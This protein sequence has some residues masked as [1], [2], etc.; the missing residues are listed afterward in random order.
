MSSTSLRPIYLVG[1]P[2]AGNAVVFELLAQASNICTLGRAARPRLAALL[3]QTPAADL[4]AGRVTSAPA[5]QL[6]RLVAEHFVDVNGNPAV[7][8]AHILHGRWARGLRVS[9]LHA[10]F[11]Q[12]R[13]IYVQRDVAEQIATIMAHRTGGS[14]AAAEAEWTGHTGQLIEDL[15]ALPRHLWCTVN[16]NDLLHDVSHEAASLGRFIDVSWSDLSTSGPILRRHQARAITRIGA[17]LH[18]RPA[19]LTMAT[20]AAGLLYGHHPMWADLANTQCGPKTGIL[21]STRVGK[22]IVSARLAAGLCLATVAM[23]MLAKAAVFTVMNNPGPRRSKHVA[24]RSQC[25]QRIDRTSKCYH[26]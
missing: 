9:F 7:R 10:L 26:L 3:Q 13:F 8:G 20:Q 19:T 5:L 4:T 2:C 15:A 18:L 21:R 12:A 16:Y 1:A 11:P 24:R 6:R 23:P 14:Q 17:S 25:C 22:S